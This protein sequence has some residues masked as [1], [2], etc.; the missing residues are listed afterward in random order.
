MLNDLG[1]V[2][3]PL[4]NLEEESKGFNG[5]LDPPQM[6]LASPRETDRPQVLL[7]TPNRKNAKDAATSR[8]E[9]VKPLD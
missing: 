8:I 9:K 4:N 3:T 2:N 1:D 6:Y 5:E 7:H